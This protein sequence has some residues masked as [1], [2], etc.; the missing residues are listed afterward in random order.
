MGY[1]GKA[2]KT[3]SQDAQDW[4]DM[5]LELKPDKRPSADKAL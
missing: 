3:V 5:M 2:W 1:E 4:I